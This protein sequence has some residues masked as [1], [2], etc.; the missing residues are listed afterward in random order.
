MKLLALTLGLLPL[1]AMAGQT[2]NEQIDVPVNKRIFIENQRGDV[3]IEGWDKPQLKI[4]GELDDKAEGYRLDVEG[5]RVEFIVK[6]PRNLRGWN[7]GD[8]SRLTIYM[9]KSSELEF[10]GV[11]VTVSAKELEAGAEIDTVN[12]DITVQKISGNM[13]FETVNGDVNAHD[14][15]GDIRFETV[16]GEINDKNSQGALRFT[17]V[18]G[19]IKSKTKAQDVRLENVNGDIDFAFDAIKKLRINTVNGEAEVHINKLLA[20]ANIRFE[21]VS[22]DAEFYFPA[23]VSAKFEIEAHANGKIVNELSDDR[24]TKAKYGPSS[25]LE[26]SINGGDADIEMDTISG[27]IEL[28]KQK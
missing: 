24:A 17:A 10:A 25:D 21:S 9:P 13:S 5:S 27:R 19:D 26:F 22:G 8:G 1:M 3:R 28:R 2:I 12:G 7:N 11:N 23:A 18:N 15:N 16:N 20:D 6:M 4:E 14:L